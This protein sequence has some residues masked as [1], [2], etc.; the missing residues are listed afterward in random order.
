MGTLPGG[1]QSEF[2]FPTLAEVLNGVW[3]LVPSAATLV[4]VILVALVLRRWLEGP[5]G[6]PSGHQ[7][8]NQLILLGFTLFGLVVAILLLPIG[9][10]LRS[11]ILSMLGI[12]FSAG[13]A[14]ASTSFLGNMLAG[15]MLRALRSFRIGDFIE[16]EGHFGRVSE[17]G[18]FHTEIQTEERNLTTLPNLYLISNPVTTV[19]PS[20]TFVSASVSL[21]YDVPRHRI[22]RLLLQAA[23]RAGL[24]EAFVLT[25]ELGDFSVTYRVAG[26]LTEVKS[27]ITAR[28]RLRGQILDSLHEGGVEIVS[29][30]FMNTRALDA[31]HVFIP[32]PAPREA[33]PTPAESPLPEAVLFDK[34]EEAEVAK[35]LADHLDNVSTEMEVVEQELKKAPQHR[36][37]DLERQAQELEAERARLARELEDKKQASED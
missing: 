33:K 35:G 10:A 7:M 19:R 29:P 6:R 20:G 12:I 15:L 32:E 11:Q 4:L 30:N 25:V 26:L 28:S 8:R 22:E 5:G 16:V 21:G 13:I 1:A 14:L 17:R 3:S 34:A 31:A 18:L 24:A 23:E 27:L 36:K 37:A 2:S 9:D